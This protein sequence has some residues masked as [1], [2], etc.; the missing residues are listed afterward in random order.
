MIQE[1]IVTT[2]NAAGDVHIAPMGIHVT[3]NE[4]VILPFKPSTTLDNLLATQ[5]AVINYCDDV[6]FCWLLNRT[7]RLA[8]KRR[9]T[10][11]R[12]SIGLR[13][14]TYRSKGNPY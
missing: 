6:R 14:G 1:T 10:H 3:D 8:I 7:A 13:P 4:F 5:V 12:Q 2:Q 9:R 11:H